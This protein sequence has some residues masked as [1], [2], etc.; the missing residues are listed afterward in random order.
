MSKTVNVSAFRV[1]GRADR[2]GVDVV[3][4]VRQCFWVGGSCER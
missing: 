4:G 3:L 1:Q 2:G